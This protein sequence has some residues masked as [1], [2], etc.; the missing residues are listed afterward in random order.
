[1]KKGLTE[2]SMSPAFNSAAKL[3]DVLQVIP[4]KA[5]AN[6]FD[7]GSPVE[8]HPGS[9]DAVACARQR[10]RG[11]PGIGRGVIDLDRPNRLPAEG[12]SEL[13]AADQIQ[14]GPLGCRNSIDAALTF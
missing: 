12:R 1:M 14:Q 10:R 6:D 13:A 4:R 2:F 11:G 7:P 3:W 9:G 5:P 8:K